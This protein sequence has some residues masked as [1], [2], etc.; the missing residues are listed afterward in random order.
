MWGLTI[1]DS[2][3][4][5]APDMFLV[6]LWWIFPIWRSI[7]RHIEGS[8][9]FIQPPLPQLLCQWSWWC[10]FWLLWLLFCAALFLICPL[11]SEPLL[12]LSGTCYGP[13]RGAARRSI[14]LGWH[15]QT[16]KLLPWRAYPKKHSFWLL[17]P[18][19]WKHIFCGR[20]GSVVM[21]RA[22]EAF[23]SGPLCP[24]KQ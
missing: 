22:R 1:S 10:L 7:S 21:C 5:P 17:C 19:K 9:C 4:I 3:D 20:R 18:E 2:S 14:L 6:I 11:L 13:G 23:F 16:D 15:S 24:E 12:L 8:S